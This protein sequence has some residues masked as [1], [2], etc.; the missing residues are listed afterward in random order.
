MSDKKIM[1]ASGKSAAGKNNIKAKK[2]AEKNAQKIINEKLRKKKLQEKRSKEIQEQRRQQKEAEQK[3]QQKEENRQQRI[4]RKI[5]KKENIRNA[6]KKFRYY[7]SADFLVRV[8]YKRVFLVIILPITSLTVGIVLLVNSVFF[9]VPKDIRN[10]EFGGNLASDS[11]AQESVFNKQ[12]KNVMVKLLKEKGCK[13][14]DFYINSVIEINDE[15]KTKSLMFG[16]MSDYI[17]V[18]TIYDS[19]GKVL[20][21]SLGLKPDKEINE[22]EF[23]DEMEYGQ[24]KV[25]VAAN[26]YNRKTFEKIGTKY[27]EVTLTIGV[28]YDE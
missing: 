4:L 25:K 27:A 21:R 1:P 3:K 19:D 12:Q 10:M 6:Y 23:F 8:N 28:D 14:F 7:T 13:D 22:A 16:N 24:K 15:F 5:R 2:Q 20:F 9:N 11:I 26:A 17:L 18:A